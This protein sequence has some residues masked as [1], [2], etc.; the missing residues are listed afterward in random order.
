MTDFG[1]CH[2]YLDPKNPMSGILCKCFIFRATENDEYLC[3]CCDHDKYYHEPPSQH[4]DSTNRTSIPTSIQPSIAVQQLNEL[5][6]ENFEFNIDELITRVI[7]N[8]F[9]VINL[10]NVGPEPK[11]PRG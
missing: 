9:K 5:N 2:Q 3:A 10:F 4:F 11:I 1:K 8:D 7:R 6:V